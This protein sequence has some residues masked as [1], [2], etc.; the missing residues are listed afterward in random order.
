[1]TVL[2]HPSGYARNS[3]KASVTA[4]SEAVAKKRARIARLEQALDMT[5]QAVAQIRDARLAGPNSRWID[6]IYGALL[7]AETR[8]KT[9][10]RRVRDD[11]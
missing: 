8:L 1:M 9:E 4:I 3:E 11:R 6:M 2:N 7:Q 5:Q 10:I